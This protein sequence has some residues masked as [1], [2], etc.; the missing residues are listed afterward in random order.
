M[1]ELEGTEQGLPTRRTACGDAGRHGCVFGDESVEGKRGPAT[2]IGA[3]RHPIGDEEGV[4][5]DLLEGRRE[6]VQSAAQL[7]HPS[8]RHP[9]RQLAAH[10]VEI[11]V[12]REEQCRFKDRLIAHQLNQA[13]EFH[14]DGI[15]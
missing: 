13:C 3:A 1:A 7:N 12:P 9:T 6:C 15:P 8:R 10:I 4:R 5:F 14:G 2:D 11:N